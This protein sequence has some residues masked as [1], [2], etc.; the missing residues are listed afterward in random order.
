MCL[1]VSEVHLVAEVHAVRGV[2]AQIRLPLDA[3]CFHVGARPA[4]DRSV[5]GDAKVVDA[6]A[7]AD[8]CRLTP[9]PTKIE[10]VG[11]Y[12]RCRPVR[13]AGTQM[14]AIAGLLAE[15]LVWKLR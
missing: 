10:Q 1:L 8:Q 2:E 6:V 15:Y 11:G 3:L 4:D 12:P 9:G 14:P 5:Q 7:L 13:N